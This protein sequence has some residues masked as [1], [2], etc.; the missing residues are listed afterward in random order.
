M[1]SSRVLTVYEK[2][3]LFKYGLKA[4]DLL[5]KGELPVEYLTGKVEFGDLIVKV[6][7]HVLIPR[8]ETEEL[9]T[10]MKQFYLTLTDQLTYLEVGT[11]S[12][13]IS[14]AFYDFLSKQKHPKIKKFV[15]SDLSLF[16]LD[17]ARENFQCLFE[18]AANELVE[19]YQSDLLSA[20]PSQ[21]FNLIAANLP[22]IPSAEIKNLDTSVKN[23]E[24]LLALDGGQSGFELIN[25]FLNQIMKRDML[26]TD[27][28]VFL[29]VYETHDKKFI[30]DHFPLIAQT[31]GIQEH[32][33]QFDRHRFLSLQKL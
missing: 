18:S 2:N 3:Q 26:S 27:G 25:Q 1:S 7:Q 16:A 13:A 19:F 33:D 24:P 14:L 4:T 28:Q 30:K 8:V 11:G 5:Q 31:F 32:R 6:D 10:L 9:I 22:Y 17:L 29:E 12:G 23:Y 20:I 15:V 21:K